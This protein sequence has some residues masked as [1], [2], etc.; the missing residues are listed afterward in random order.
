MIKKPPLQ[1]IADLAW[2]NK[3]ISLKTFKSQKEKRAGA[4]K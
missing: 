1:T 4:S 3:K 2:Q